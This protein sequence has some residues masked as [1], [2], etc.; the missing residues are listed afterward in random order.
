M[1]KKLVN[2]VQSIQCIGNSRYT[3]HKPFVGALGMRVRLQDQNVA[4]VRTYLLILF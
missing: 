3:V 1:P 4:D 2:K